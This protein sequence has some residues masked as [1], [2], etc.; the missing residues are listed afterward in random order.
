ME[1]VTILVDECIWPWRGRRWCHLVSDESLDELHDFASRL[2]MP[3]RIFQG[4]HYDLHEDLRAM[5][6]DGGAI[7]VSSRVLLGRL[8]AAGLRLPPGERRNLAGDRRSAPFGLDRTTR[9]VY[10]DRVDDYIRLRPPVRLEEA[11]TFAQRCLPG[12]AVADLGCGPGGYL[13]VLPERTVGVDI[14]GPMLSRAAAVAAPA[15][16]L[17]QADLESL[18]FAPHSLGGAW[19]RNGHVHIPSGRFPW[20]LAQLQRAMAVDAPLFLSLVG[21]DRDGCHADD[22]LTGRFFARWQA[23]RVHDVVVGAGFAVEEIADEASGNIVVRAIRARTLADSVGPAMRMLVCGLNPSV[24]AADAGIGFAG[25]TNRFWPAALTAG[26]IDV[27][28]DLRH[29]LL[30]RGVGMT[31]LVKRATPKSA[32]VSR[33]EYAEGLERVARLVDWLR[34]GV[35]CMVGLEGWRAATDRRATAGWQERQLGTRP[36]YVMPS[37]SGLNAGTSMAALVDH[38]RA[39]LAGPLVR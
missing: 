2:G 30:D 15:A 12:R 11:R 16:G 13:P 8:R 31:D 37:T 27:P 20:A 7:A 25:A 38:L 26:L 32:E 28:R 36:V 35:V 19:S 4:D 6:L 9:Q 24:V 10:E 23:D 17:L 34:P 5:A 29:A 3:R 21:G 22:D 1:N 18:P 33:V 39:A 14:A